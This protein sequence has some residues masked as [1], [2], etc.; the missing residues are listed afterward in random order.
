[1]HGRVCVA[2]ACLWS[3][4]AERT[5]SDSHTHAGKELFPIQLKRRAERFPD[6]PSFGHRL[7]RV[8]ADIDQNGEFIAAEVRQG[9]PLVDHRREPAG[10]GG[11]QLIADG[12]AQ[13]VVH[14][15]EPIQVEDEQRI[16]SV[17]TGRPSE[18]PWIDARARGST[19]RDGR[20]GYSARHPQP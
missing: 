20:V 17:Q 16:G 1:M 5:Q 2:E 7:V 14:R 8:V 19:P 13:A 11:Q 4:I 18:S 12:V 6:A 10:H 3:P 15:P 9:I